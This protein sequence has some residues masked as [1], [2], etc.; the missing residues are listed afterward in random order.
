STGAALTGHN[1]VRAPL[2]A[3]TALATLDEPTAT[4]DGGGDETATPG[5]PTETATPDP[6]ETSTTD[7]SETPGPTETVT[8]PNTAAAAAHTNGHG[9]DDVLFANGRGP[10]GPIGCDVG[11]SGPHRKNGVPK[12][13][14]T[15][16]PAAQEPG[17]STPPTADDD[18]TTSEPGS[19]SSTAPDPHANGRGCDDVLATNG[20]GPGGPVGCEAGNSGPHRQ[21]GAKNAAPG[22]TEAASPG[23]TDQPDSPA[24]SQ[25]GTQGKGNGQGVG[26]GGPN[27]GQG[28]GNGNGKNK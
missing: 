4:V 9:C 7:L 24:A 22:P 25:P 8:P 26:K 28:K 10:G 1:P 15:G 6:G 23:T 14:P 20:R 27:P 3:V 16:T 5:T 18:G 11:N 19:D 2:N 13:T 17:T 21:N 12:E